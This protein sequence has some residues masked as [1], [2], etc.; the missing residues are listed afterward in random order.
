M[1]TFQNPTVHMHR[2]EQISGIS[3][4]LQNLVLGKPFLF[5]VSKPND[6]EDLRL[7]I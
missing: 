6:T 3:D 4:A 7:F 2:H 1:V 5:T